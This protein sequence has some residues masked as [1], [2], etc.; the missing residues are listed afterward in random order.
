MKIEIWSDFA[1]PY[2]Y[3]G[4]KMLEQAN[5]S[6]SGI[7]SVPYFV[8]DNKVAVSGTK[9]VEHFIGAINNTLEI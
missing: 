6:S 9:S 4:E 3:L 7:H 8:I 2:C 5:S 1:C